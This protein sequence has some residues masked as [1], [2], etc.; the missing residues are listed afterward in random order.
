MW[1]RSQVQRSSTEC[2]KCVCVID[3]DQ[4]QHNLLHL[5]VRRR[6][7]DKTDRQTCRMYACSE[8]SFKSTSIYSAYLIV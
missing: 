3:C 5:P 6:G 8:D 1:D 7:Q 2:D 4:V